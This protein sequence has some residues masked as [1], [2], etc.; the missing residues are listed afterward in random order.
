MLQRPV[1][2]WKSFWLGPLVLIALAFLWVVSM[3]SLRGVAINS[4]TGWTF[5]GQ[6]EGEICLA[7]NSDISPWGAGSK[8]TL[9]DEYGT[10][11]SPEYGVWWK[12]TIRSGLVLHYWHLALL[13]L[14]PWAAFLGWRW[15]RLKGVQTGLEASS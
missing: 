8:V 6:F 11:G 9:I 1:H 5:A 7:P 15:R 2:R 10:G 3:D 14:V 12:E 4:A 13:F